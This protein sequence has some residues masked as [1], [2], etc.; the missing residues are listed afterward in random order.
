[1]AFD[2]RLS[3]LLNG[4]AYRLSTLEKSFFR[5]FSHWQFNLQRH[6]RSFLFNFY[7]L[8]GPRSHVLQLVSRVNRYAWFRVPRH[9]DDDVLFYYFVSFFRVLLDLNSDPTF[10]ITYI[11]THTRFIPYLIGILA[12]YVYYKKKLHVP[13][14]NKQQTLAS[15]SI[16]LLSH[17]PILSAI[18]FYTP[19][20]KYDRTHASIY[21]AFHRI[22]WCLAISC[23]ILMGATRNGGILQPILSWKAFVPLSRLTYCVFLSHGAIQLYS[24]SSL[25]TPDYNSQFK[26][27]SSQF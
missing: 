24:T 15:V 19:G 6:G 2:L 13:L 23:L 1:M 17:I 26:I 18:L 12:S 21:A 27:V 10:R 22:P 7:E 20:Y 11:P 16:L 3:L 14:S 5:H 9:S 8:P 4:P 25:R